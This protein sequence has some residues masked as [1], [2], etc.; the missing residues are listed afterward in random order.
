M[1]IIEGDICEIKEGYLLQQSNCVSLFPKGLAKTLENKFPG[2]CPYLK[3]KL[4]R[5]NQATKDT[6]D[7]PGSI[8]IVDYGDI[9]IV[10][11]FAQYYPGKPQ[12]TYEFK[13]TYDERKKF[14]KICLNTLEDYLKE[15]KEYIK[16]NIPYKIGCGLAGGIWKDY[17]SMI[18]D[19]EKRNKHLEINI[20]K[21]V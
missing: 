8:E 9:K 20:F 19:F 16:I 7:I 3:R 17:L 12:Q 18:E 10:S 11:M 2:C 5:Y 4:L 1:K 21:N 14:F 15:N 6:R 13:D